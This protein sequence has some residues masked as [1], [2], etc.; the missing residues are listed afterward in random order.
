MNR[1]QPIRKVKISPPRFEYSYIYI[2][3]IFLGYLSA[4]L[5][6]TYIRDNFLPLSPTQVPVA[7]RPY[8]SEPKPM[9]NYQVITRKN[10]FNSDGVIAKKLTSDGE[11]QSPED[12]PAE[13]TKLPISLV[14]TIVHV[15]GSKSVASIELKG[16][17]KIVAYEI[18]DE[19]ENMAVLKKVERRKI[20]IK[21]KN[22]NRMEFAEIKEDGKLSFGV[23][24]P[25]GASKEITVEGNQ[26]KINKSF[27]DKTLLQIPEIMNQASGNFHR[28]AQ[29]R[30]DGYQI[31]DIDPNSV[32]SQMGLLPNDIIKTV[33]GQPVDNP[34]KAM[35]IFNDVKSSNNIQIGINRNGRDE[36]HSVVITQ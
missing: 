5:I 12:L 36:D 33:N 15:D 27:L 29:G 28:D 31:F 21:N 24:S 7:S 2:L 8:T 13:P 4:D 23:K 3:M 6:T 25:V 35:Q 32:L 17:G 26:V 34:A 30:I 14:G 11:Q 20:L 10:I 19:I 1:I 9:S 18:E 22:T 16:R